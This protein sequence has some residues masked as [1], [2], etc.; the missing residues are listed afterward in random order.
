MS[1]K[2]GLCIFLLFIVG[3]LFVINVKASVS[4]LGVTVN[5]PSVLINKTRE[6]HPSNYFS[7]R[8]FSPELSSD[9][10]PFPKSKNLSGLCAP[11]WV[12]GCGGTDTWNNSFNGATDQIDGYSCSSWDKSGPEYAY[13]FTTDLSREVTVQLRNMDADLDLFIL[14]NPTGNCNSDNCITYGNDTATFNANANQTYYLVVDG[15]N[16]AVGNYTIDI[17]CEASEPTATPTPPY[18]GICVPQDFLYCGSWVS[19]NNGGIGSTNQIDSYSCVG[20]PESGP[21][22]AYELIPN[23]AGEVTIS[24]LYLT[25]DLDVFILNNATGNCN[26]DNCIAYGDNSTTFDVAYGQ[27]YYV[28]VDGYGGA[29][30]DYDLKVQ[31]EPF[32]VVPIFLPIV[33][34]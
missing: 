10:T 12:L 27:T 5:K 20:Y 19:S 16:G 11:A 1:A 13:T 26:A 22:M 18:Q 15:C 23:M 21:E 34:R 7:Q 33:S 28:V 32:L 3:S 29:V 31:C 4:N 9:S 24:L 2:R 6:P 14:D 17:Q 25:Q 8:V 30:S